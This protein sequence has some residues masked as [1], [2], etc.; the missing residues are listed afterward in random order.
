V[1]AIGEALDLGTAGWKCARARALEPGLHPVVLPRKDWLRLLD[2]LAHA[3][4]PL[5]LLTPDPPP[6]SASAE[7]KGVA[8]HLWFRNAPGKDSVPARAGPLRAQIPRLAKKGA[9]TVIEGIEVLLFWNSTAE[10]VELLLYL[11]EVLE[12]RGSPGVMLVRPP[13]LREP[14]I[15]AIASAAPRHRGSDLTRSPGARALH[16]P[17]LASRGRP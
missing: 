4:M 16:A 15:A 6:R 11:G 9:V 14:E 7:P 10:V 17:A 5:L 13:L 8:D 1:A 2:S 3:G 12:E